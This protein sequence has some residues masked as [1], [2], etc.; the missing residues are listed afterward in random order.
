MKIL[1]EELNEKII[2]S[3]QLQAGW[4][5]AGGPGWPRVAQGGPFGQRPWVGYWAGP[6]G[7]LGTL[8]HVRE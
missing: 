6:A 4:A 5:R 3:L 8:S 2:C 7:L 1:K